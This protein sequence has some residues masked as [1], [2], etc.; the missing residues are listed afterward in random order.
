[1]SPTSFTDA[2]SRRGRGSF[3]PASHF[4]QYVRLGGP[5]VGAGSAIFALVESVTSL[6]RTRRLFGPE[7]NPI[8]HEW[9]YG[10]S[11]AHEVRLC[12]FNADRFIEEMDGFEDL[13]GATPTPAQRNQRRRDLQERFG[14]DETPCLQFLLPDWGPRSPVP[15]RYLRAGQWFALELSPDSDGLTGP[16]VHLD[17]ALSPD[18][19]GVR[20]RLSLIDL[21]PPFIVERLRDIFSL[22][23]VLDAE[24]TE[25]E[26]GAGTVRPPVPEDPAPLQDTKLSQDVATALV[27]DT[28]I[29]R[30]NRLEG[31]S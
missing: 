16:E 28:P 27:E 25:D 7:G 14:N 5:P 13:L 22:A 15:R 9:P 11:R 2:S 3:D 29:A 10:C 6:T 31:G 1:M 4:D 8:R 21:P 17:Q 26:N 18:T 20:M 23:H 12:G 24:F 19:E 30:L